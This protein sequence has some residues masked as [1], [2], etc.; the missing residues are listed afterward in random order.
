MLAMPART[1]LWILCVAGAGLLSAQAPPAA[2]NPAVKQIVDSVD[3]QR[4]EANLR[5]LEGFGT[6]YI[7]SEQESPQ[8]GIGAAKRWIHD[9]FRSYSPKLQVRY[10]DFRIRKGARLGQV[11]HEVELSNVIAVLPGTVDRENYV[12]V[13]AHYDTISLRRKPQMNNDERIATMVKRGMDP[14]EARRVVQL[15]PTEDTLGEVDAEATAAEKNSPGVVDDASGTAAVMELA[16]VMSQHTFEKTLVFVAF[17]GE[18]IGL[19]GSKVYA[20]DARKNGIRIEAV[21]N[22]DIIGSDTS[23]NGRANSSALRV[24]AAGPEDSPG[25]AL[26]RYTKLLAERYVPSMNV[27]MVFHGDRF[28]RGGDHTSFQTQG[29]A[30]VRLTSASENFENQHSPS[31]TLTNASVP[32]T[33][34]VTRMNAAVAASLALAP[35]PPVVNYTYLSGDRKGDRQ[36]M[37]SRGKSG[38]DAA[39]RWQ[40]SP[41]PDLAGYAVVIRSTT[42]PDWEREIW[43]GNVTSFTLPD[44]SIDNIVLGVKAVDRDGN[45]SLV[46]AYLEPVS[47]SLTAP[48]AA[49]TGKK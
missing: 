30:A 33:T 25:R 1:K 31:D 45:Q 29:Y 22:N 47:R 42:A 49:P 9:E 38:Y 23:G 34:R 37:L 43:V 21:L 24:F 7:L 11:L 4:I 39:L 44:V 8:R 15:F 13:T 28:N 41:A 40:P 2:L 20:A 46:S 14:A 35:P 48:P 32:Y 3:S 17:A 27:E 16:R 5:K 19:E 18:E 26:L 10:Q 12:L 36:P 6:R